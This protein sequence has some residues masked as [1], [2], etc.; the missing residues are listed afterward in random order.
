MQHSADILIIAI[1]LII[2]GLIAALPTRNHGA[3][4]SSRADILI[5]QRQRAEFIKAGVK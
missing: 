4:A 5:H 2:I 1:T 3:T